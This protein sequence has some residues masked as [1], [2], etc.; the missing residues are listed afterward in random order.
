MANNNKKGNKRTFKDN[1]NDNNDNLK[2]DISQKKNKVKIVNKKQLVEKKI[3]SDTSDD[4]STHKNIENNF[5]N[6][7]TSLIKD[8]DPTKNPWGNESNKNP[9]GNESNKN[10]WNGEPIIVKAPFDLFFPKSSLQEE[11]KDEK[12][13]IKTDIDLAS[14]AGDIKKLDNWLSKNIDSGSF[15]LKHADDYTSEALDGASFNNKIDV[16][17]WWLENN[18]K[19]GL[20]L[21]YTERTMI[22]AS[23][24]GLI[25]ILNWWY[26]SKLFLK[27][28]ENAINNASINNKINVLDWWFDK[29]KE[30]RI[31]FK[32]SQ[33][34]FDKCKLA[35]KDMLELLK[36]WKDKFDNHNM[37][38]LYGKEF[39]DFIVYNNYDEVIKY[40]IENKLLTDDDVKKRPIKRLGLNNLFEMF[41][42]P[43]KEH[44]SKFDT[45]TLPKDIQDHIKEKEEELNNNMLINGKAKEYIDNL[46]KIPFGKY[47]EEKIFKF[48]NELIQKLNTKYKLELKNES[49]LLEY[50]KN[51]NNTDYYTLYQQ[52]CEYR[53]KYLEYVDKTLDKCVY[54]HTQTKKQIK[55]ILAQWLSGG[56]KKGVVIGIQ[57]PP[58]V[59]KTTIIKG[60]LALCIVDFID[61]NLD[62]DK[63][64]E[65]N[66]NKLWIKI[67]E[68]SCNVKRP[69]CFISLGGST[70]SSTLIGH[71]ITYHGATSGDIVKSLKEAKYMNPILYFDELDKISKTEHGNE[72]SSVLTHI[73]DP[74]QNEHFT[75]RYFSEVKIDLSKCIIIFSYN[76]STKIDR[77]LYDRIQEIKLQAIPLLEKVEICKNFL[78]P[79]ILDNMG[80]NKEN[81]VLSNNELEN[82]ILGYTY[83]AGVRKIKEKLNEILRNYHLNRLINNQSIANEVLTN[84]YVD[85][86]LNDHHKILLKKI[87]PKPA[88][89]CIHGM[90]ATTNGL[91]DVMLIQVKKMYNKDLLGLHTTGS[92]E[93][94][95]TESIQVARTVAWNLLTDDE[96]KT[97]ETS[98]VNTGLH[99]HCPDGST[100]KDGPSAGTAITTAIYSLLTGKLI[101]NDV[102][103]TGE[104]D[105]DGNVTAIGGLDAK[106]SGAKRAGIKLA[107]VP[108]ENKR[109]VE[110]L[111][112]KNTTLIDSK[113][114]V[115]FISHVNEA[116]KIVIK[117]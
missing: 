94:V 29:I 17:S 62:E 60:A 103:I 52:F 9:W 88:I 22:D 36:W 24:L 5:E 66:Q 92:L 2:N 18:R 67:I 90:Y 8:F 41:G 1:L 27:Y 50:F 28:N 110:I 111:L 76:D 39:I 49:D 116:L 75:D 99:I 23:R 86:I 59:G 42:N 35:E 26:D 70:N 54:G 109:D 44:S 96:R 15:D 55:C 65:D 107:L 97:I 63:S 34:A 12:K 38:F 93:K 4:E 13:I 89:G 77:I 51:N 114:K 21:K 31:E 11:K 20:P 105:L 25:N 117:H 16:L 98:F 30:K 14:F 82:I 69:F 115:K 84:D 81:I 100:P 108:L 112:K 72:I 80:Y 40:L 3:L 19:Y 74:A 78:I 33:S 61:Y 91:G 102:A 37:L 10:I 46:V 106:L 85:N 7:L 95:I 73:T 43:K 53:I 83:E 101:K 58:G 57:G 48:I 45:S 68:E 32:Y 6:M 113:F 64:K 71:N 87:T 104:I 56:I 47:R 79:E